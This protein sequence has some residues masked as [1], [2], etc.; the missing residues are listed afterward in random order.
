MWRR[1]Q[2]LFGS[3]QGVPGRSANQQ[4]E[5][6]ASEAPP[7]SDPP[8][9]RALTLEEALDWVI[10]NNGQ[11]GEGEREK[12][13]SLAGPPGA[14]GPLFRMHTPSPSL[15]AAAHSGVLQVLGFSPCL[16][17]TFLPY[18]AITAI[19]YVPQF[20]P[21][22]GALAFEG[23]VDGVEVLISAVIPEEQLVEAR[24][25][26]EHVAALSGVDVEV[27]RHAV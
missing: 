13:L 18:E 1:L 2:N 17:P 5:P 24:L 7:A 22:D 21:T 6:P 9:L 4:N 16:T 8:D 23:M 26:V 25:L 10:E 11:I 27:L 3:Q 14:C 19:K 15:L 12:V 20:T